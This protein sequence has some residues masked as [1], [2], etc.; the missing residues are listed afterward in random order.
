MR[1]KIRLLLIEDNRLL[2]LATARMLRRQRDLQVVAILSGDLA[3]VQQARQTKP[4]VILLDDLRW[5]DVANRVWPRAR[6]IVTDLDPEQQ[7]IHELLRAR[8][9]G[10]LL[11]EATRDDFLRV[12]RAVWGGAHVLPASVS[13]ALLAK[14]AEPS[15]NGNGDGASK[16]GALTSRER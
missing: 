2:R 14:A 3:A 15:A 6:V 9:A 10:F 12:I 16:S 1:K 8:V 7:D 4:D 13:A 5:L 11:K